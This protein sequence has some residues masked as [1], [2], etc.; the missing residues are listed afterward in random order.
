MKRAKYVRRGNGGK[1]ASILTILLLFA[2]FSATCFP[3]SRALQ[4]VDLL[5]LARD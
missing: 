1:V 2:L 4:K 3:L 5:V